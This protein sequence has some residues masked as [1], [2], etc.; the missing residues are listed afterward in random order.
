MKKELQM[1]KWL[2]PW[3]LFV[4]ISLTLP[5]LANLWFWWEGPGKLVAGLVGMVGLISAGGWLWIWWREGK[6]GLF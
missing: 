4:L 2:N 3:R 5:G 1:P 6:I